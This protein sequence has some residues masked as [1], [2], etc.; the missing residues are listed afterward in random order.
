MEIHLPESRD[1]YRILSLPMLTEVYA[2]DERKGH[3]GTSLFPALL[4][5][6]EM[7]HKGMEVLVI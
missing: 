6:K 5:Y 1:A 3:R 7:K 4:K 2:L